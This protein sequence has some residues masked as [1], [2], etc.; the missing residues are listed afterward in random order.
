[1]CVVLTELIER[2]LYCVERERLGEHRAIA[3]R[4]VDHVAGAAGGEEERNAACGEPF[5]NGPALLAAAQMHVDNRGIDSTALDRFD[6][7]LDRIGAAREV[8]VDRI[9]K[10]LE[11]H[12]D[13]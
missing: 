1:M 10:I 3:P 9:E 6:R 4:V 5:A 8:A 7:G 2:L 12:R 13:Q 11:H